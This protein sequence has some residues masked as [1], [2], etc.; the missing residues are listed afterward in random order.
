MNRTR[1]AIFV[2]ACCPL[3]PGQSPAA[4][5]IGRGV[6]QE[7]PLVPNRG[8]GPNGVLFS[9]RGQGHV[10]GLTRQGAVLRF[11]NKVVRM[12]FPGAN[13]N[14]QI[15]GLDLQSG[16]T[17]Y[18]IGRNAANW[19]TDVPTYGRVQ[20]SDMFP[21]TDLLFYANQRQWEYDLV[22]RRGA[23]PK[24]I[25]MLFEGITRPGLSPGGDLILSS[26]L[27]L[28]K[29][30]A[31]QEINGTQK[32]IPSRYILKRHNRVAFALGRYDHSLPLVID[33]ILS[34]ATYL[35]GTSDEQAYAVATDTAGNSYVTGY[36]ASLDFPATSGAYKT[37]NQGGT[38]DVFV[39]KYSPTGALIYATYLGG[40]GD[41]TAYGIA[42]DS[43]GNAY[44]TGSTTS[45]DFPT[46]VGAYRTTYKGGNSD[47]FVV[48]L[49]AA[50]DGLV[51]SSYLGG[52]GDDAAYSVALDSA[53][54]ATV[55]GATNSSDFPA[56]TGAYGAFNGGG[57]ADAFV[58]RL[59]AAG[60]ALIYSTYLGGAGEDAA[61]GVAVDSAGNAYVTGYTQSANFPT[62]P[63]AAQ[64][65][66]A[67]DY[68]AFVTALNPIGTA[69]L[70]S[71]LLGG[72]QQDYGVGVA[73]DSLGNAYMTGYTAS[74]DYPH[75]S[76]A[77][78]PG[79]N[80]GYDAVVTKLTGFG[81][82]A[83]ST[84]LGG[85][86]DDYGMAIAVDQSGNAYITGDTDSTDFPTAAG[87]IQTAATGVY[88]AFVTQVSA[89]GTALAYSTYLGGSGF[90]TGY[91]IALDPSRA[92]WVAGY[93]VSSDFPVTKG[94]AQGA[95][96]GGSDAFL[97]KITAAPAL[98]INKTADA[99]TVNA[100]SAIGFTIAAG[101]G[102]AASAIATTV[103]LSDPLPSGTGVA[104]SISPAYSSPGMCAITG[105]AGSQS[106]GC[107]F[108]SLAAG[109]TA[110]VH[111]SSATS[112]GGCQ[113]YS[114]TATLTADNSATL[115]STATTTT[116][117]CPA[118]SVTGPAS[119]P[120]GTVGLAYP[121]TTITATGGVGTY[122]WSATGLPGGLTMGSSTGT[123][124]GTPN[125]ATG[126]PFSVDVA[127]TDSH[128]TTAHRGYTL[129]VST[130]SACD[131]GQNG[132]INVADV[133]LV[134]NEALGATQAANDLNGDGAVNVVDIQLEID[135]VL[136]LG[137]A[138]R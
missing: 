37:A 27:R 108:G 62:T 20:Y 65:S 29:P 24:A 122:T 97:V 64:R 23:D 1:N 124:T 127:V 28:L 110:S 81:T 63:G 57:I 4:E 95:V 82:I 17:N 8:Q 74:S 22:L 33:P 32:E 38:S 43:S 137:C 106:L 101:N 115:Q 77:L 91:G 69:A 121:A 16:R 34:Y 136:G 79:K 125:T 118:L 13:A 44:I 70:Y 87:A 102:A 66:N 41:D 86:G 72:S 67:G 50:G 40:S 25:V 117:Q 126:S 68:D 56:S 36:T 49:N 105:A 138:A 35:G 135:A 73:V 112:T 21:G 71:T 94:S 114:N 61:Y 120:S 134:V 92:A 78:Q 133:Q 30:H 11:E 46:T 51:Y 19:G 93:T 98:S 113:T 12:V 128:P 111:V 100:G 104:W 123:I 3:W 103:A 7:S 80:G 130:F 15:S 42:V 109:A 88:N 75:T 39:A 99:A 83:Y 9:S 6:S 45:T 52:S 76:G 85:S 48:K 131:I 18:L 107:G 47:A 89:A 55:A 59:S 116:V 60:N 58:T 84:F 90:E 26:D 5:I 129:M 31:Y 2:V 96:A 54:E 119:L 132:N 10:I 53:N 14:P